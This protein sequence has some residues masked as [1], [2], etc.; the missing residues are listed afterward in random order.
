ME[1]A[2][3]KGRFMEGPVMILEAMAWAQRVFGSCDL[4]DRRRE[5]RLVKVGAMLA[6]EPGQSL[7]KASGGDEAAEE[8]ATV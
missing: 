8:G 6:R 4:G 5:E 1:P 2:G 3:D 7:V